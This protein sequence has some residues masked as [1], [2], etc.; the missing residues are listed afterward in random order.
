MI[1]ELTEKIDAVQL[2]VLLDLGLIVELEF[3]KF[4]ETI[5]QIGSHVQMPSETLSCSV[6]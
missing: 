5:N 4:L 3:V 1:V 6:S 2:E